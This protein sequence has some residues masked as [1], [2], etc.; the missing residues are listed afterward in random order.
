MGRHPVYPPEGSR[1]RGGSPRWRDPYFCEWSQVVGDRVRRLRRRQELS[2]NEL[3]VMVQKPEGGNYSAGYYSR[4][5]RGWA[6]APLYAYLALSEALGVEPGR[7]L[8]MEDVDRP[9]SEAE[10]TL[11]LFL[12]GIG[13]TPDEALVRLAGPK[14]GTPVEGSAADSP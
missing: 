4:L 9:V 14:A 2:L 7:L 13:V 10:M 12:R 8:G 6:S 3:A 5:E 11:L 1:S